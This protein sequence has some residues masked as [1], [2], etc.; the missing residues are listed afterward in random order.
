M[1][2]EWV[3]EIRDLCARENVPFFFKQAAAYQ[4]GRETYLTEEDGS[5]WQYHQ[6]P[7]E[8]TAPVRVEPDKR[9]K[10]KKS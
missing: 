3:R 8:L 5:S 10:C 9:A 6:Y 4:T 2:M 7:G 1:R